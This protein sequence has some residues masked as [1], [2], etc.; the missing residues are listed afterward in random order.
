LMVTLFFIDTYD[1]FGLGT[2]V[3]QIGPFRTILDFP[4]IEGYQ[5]VLRSVFTYPFGG[6]APII[7]SGRYLTTTYSFIFD[8]IQQ[9]GVFALIGLL[10]IGVF[11]TNQLIEF[12]KNKSVNLSIRMTLVWLVTMFM[13]YQ[14][15][16]TQLYPYIREEIRFTPRLILDEPL[17]MVM[18]F[19]MGTIM[20]DPFVGF[21]AMNKTKQKT[22]SKTKPK[23][24]IL[25]VKKPKKETK[26]RKEK[27]PSVFADRWKVLD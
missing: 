18:V 1:V 16:Q 3:K 19:L 23:K 22:K 10:L 15:F 21:L 4:L 26:L 25:P 6:F 9:A 8:T 24:E 14:T 11:F 20:I 17:W 7:V 12:S 13:V 2:L 27:S 5:E